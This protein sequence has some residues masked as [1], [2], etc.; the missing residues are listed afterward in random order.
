MSAA[1]KHLPAWLLASLLGLL[2]ALTGC[3]GDSAPEYALSEID[4]K[5]PDLQFRLPDARGETR[6][7]QDF[8]GKTVLMFFGYTHCPDVCPMTLSRIRRA[9]GNLD[10]ENAQRVRVLFVSVDPRRDTPEA[11]RSY[12]DGFDMP[13]LVGLRGKGSGFE[14]LKER[15]HLYVN[16]HREGP[17]DQEYE[18]DHSGQVYIFGPQGEAR[19]MARLSGKQPDSVDTLTT[20]LRKLLNHTAG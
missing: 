15:Y 2:L 20:D 8:Q 1:R 10:A 14:A 11:I 6:T 3:N 12:V 19:L 4:G 16:R 18:V 7:A 5:M 17:E 13:Q 9:V